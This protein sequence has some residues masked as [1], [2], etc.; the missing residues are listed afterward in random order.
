MASV[1]KRVPV[2]L[3]FAHGRV[4]GVANEVRVQGFEDGLARQ[5]FRSHGGGVRHARAAQRL[6]Q[7]FLDDAVLHVQ[8]QLAGALLGCAPAHTVGQA[9]DV[10]DFFRFHPFAFFRDGSRSVVGTF[11]YNTHVFNFV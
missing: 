3:Q 10:Y 9:G 7:A 6:D 4:D 11:L 2:W 5:D 8:R 1:P